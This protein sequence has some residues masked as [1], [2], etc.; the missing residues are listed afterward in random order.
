MHQQLCKRGIDL[1]ARASQADELFKARL[2]DFFSSTKKDDREMKEIEVL[3]DTHRDA[4][5][6]FHR[7]KRI[8]HGLRRSSCGCPAVCRCHQIIQVHSR[9]RRFRKSTKQVRIVKASWPSGAERFYR[10]ERS[11]KSR[12]QALSCSLTCDGPLC[13]ERIWAGGNTCADTS[14]SVRNQNAPLLVDSGVD[15]VEEIAIV[16]A[17]GS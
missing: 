10:L 5:E 14:V 7:H 2:L 13:A 15:E 17:G 11:I 8:L 9:L 16:A 6:A 4:D 12:E 3:G 1:F